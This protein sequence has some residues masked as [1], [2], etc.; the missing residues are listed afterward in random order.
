MCLRGDAGREGMS[1]PSGHVGRRA[2]I[3]DRPGRMTARPTGLT[4]RS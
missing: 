3:D 4:D 1:P 2:A